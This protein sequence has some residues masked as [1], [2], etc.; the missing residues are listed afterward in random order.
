MRRILL[1]AVVA[2]VGA[3]TAVV[4]AVEAGARSGCPDV[5]GNIQSGNVCHVNVTT[6]GYIVDFRFP[7]DYVDQQPVIDFLTQERNRLVGLAQAPGAKRLPYNLYVTWEIYSSGSLQTTTRQGLGYGQPPHGT[8][9]LVLTEFLD[10]EG[11]GQPGFNKPKTFTY[12]LNQNRSLTF[13]NLFAPGTN[14]IDKI[15]P[16]VATD[17]ARQQKARD[18][19]LSPSVGRDPAHYQNFAVTDDAVIFFFSA[20]EFFDVEAGDA[21]T[22]IP[23]VLLPPLQI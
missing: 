12:D 10:A 8:Q 1:L 11:A 21:H 2:L 17:L 15:Y 5:G 20:G 22:V 19:H 18:F 23:R 9:S 4:G 14:P 16:A 3:L 6:P 7:T 13:G